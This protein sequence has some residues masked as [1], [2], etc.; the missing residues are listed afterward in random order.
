LSINL[1]SAVWVHGN[2]VQV[3]DPERLTFQRRY[4]FAAK[5]IGN[6]RH[7]NWFHFPM[8]TPVIIDDVRPKLA[9]VFVFYNARSSVTINELRVLDGHRRVKAF[10][11]LNWSG[12]HGFSV[13]PENSRTIDP[14]E[15]ILFGLGISIKVSFGGDVEAESRSQIDFTAAG[16]DFKP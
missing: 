16:A 7:E 11:N 13:Q 3:Q 10:E 8:P 14:P 6:N 12:D 2:I 1:K 5:F 15:T 4:D 9:K